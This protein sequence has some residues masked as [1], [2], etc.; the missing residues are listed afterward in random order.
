MKKRVLSVLLALSM[1]LGYILPAGS[2]TALAAEG[3]SSVGLEPAPIGKVTVENVFIDDTG[4]N[5]LDTLLPSSASIVTGE[6][7]DSRAMKGSFSVNDP[8]MVITKAM[9]EGK[10]FTVTTRAYIPGS[11]KGE[12]FNMFVSIG[13]MS[14]SFRLENGRPMAFVSDGDAWFN[15]DNRVDPD[16]SFGNKW[17]DLAVSYTGTTLIVF[18]DG[19]E[20]VVNDR[21]TASI[22]NSGVP[23]SVGFDPS[24]GRYN[25]DLLFED[26]VV[27]NEALTVEELA[28]DHAATDENILLWM[29]FEEDLVVKEEVDSGMDVDKIK[30]THKEWTG[31]DYTDVDGKAVTGEDVFGINREDASVPRIPYQDAATAASSA[32]DYNAR[33]NSVYF[34]LLTGEDRTWDLTVVQNQTL[35]QPFMDEGFMTA[36]Y[37]KDEADGWK[38]VT[39]PLSW[40]R[41]GQD[42]DFSIY[43][44]TQMPWQSKYDSNVRV[45]TAP[46][47]YNPVGLY[48]HTFEVSD[49]MLA[50]NRRIYLSFQGVESAYYVYLN[51]KEVGY[52]EDSY[53]PHRFDITDYLIDGENLLAVKV[54]KFCD[55][56]WFEDQDM[57]YDGGIFRDVYI[58]SE[59]LVKIE[60]YTV[61]TDLDADYSNAT[62]KISADVRNMSTA[63]HSGWTIQVK[64]IDESGEDILNGA[65]I[66][67]DAV[68]STETGTFEASIP[69]T[70]PK[71][72]SA[73]HPNLYAL[74]LTLV[75]GEGNE[76]E[77]LATQLGFRE[78][79]FTR[80]EVDANG[81][82]TT[83]TWTPVKINGQRLLLKGANRHDS[84]PI[85]GKTIPQATILEDLKLMKQFNFNAIRTSHYSNDEF[86]YWACNKYGIYMMAETNMECHAIMG[87]SGNIGLFY[88]LGLDRTETTFE[89]LKNN[90]AIVM[91][92]I[93]N[94]M[95]YTSDA[96]FG[97]GIFRDMIRFFKNNDATRLV[98]S[99][100]QN[101]SLGTDMGSNMYPSVGTVQGKA[102]D[103]K[104]PYVMCEYAHGMGNSIGHLKEYWDAIRSGENMLGG[105]V[106]DWVDQSRAV[107]LKDLGTKYIFTDRTGVEGETIGT[108]DQWKTEAG[109]GSLNGGHSFS[110]YTLLQN[111][112]YNKALS[113][114]GKSFTFEVIVK[115]N[116]TAQNSVLMAKGDSQVALKTKSSG[117]GIEFFFYDGS[118]HAAEGVFPENWVGNWHQVVGVYD[119]GTLTLYCDGV[120][121]GTA[122]YTDSIN[123]SSYPI[124][125]GRDPEKGRNVDG[126]ISIARIYTKALTVEEIKAQNSAEPAI[127]EDD[128]SVLLWVDYSDERTEQQLAGWDYYSED[129][130]H[131]NLYAEEME[132]KFFGYGGDWGDRPNDNSFCQNGVVSADRTPQP[133]LYE[134]KYQHQGFWFSADMEDLLSGNISVYNEY[135]FSNLNE[136]DVVWELVENGEV[137]DEGTVS[138][139]NVAPGANGTVQVNYAAP[140]NVVAGSEY[141]LNLSVR[142]K[143][144]TDLVPAGHEVAW[145]QF[146]VPVEVA[147]ARIQVSENPV[148]VKDTD[149]AIEVS[150]ENFS[151]AINKENGIMENYV[152]GG[153]LLMEQGPA[154]SFWCALTENHE[155]TGSNGIDGG[156]EGTDKNIVVESIETSV[157][158]DGRNVI[159]A[160]LI[161]PDAGN[162]SETIV[163]T[164]NGGGEVTVEMTVDATKSGMGGFV[165][166]GSTATLPAGFENITWYG[167]GPVETF[168]DRKTNARQGIWNTTVNEF[169]YP[170][171]KVDTSVLTD[172][173]WM[174]VANEELDNALVVVGQNFVETS[175]FH[176]TDED[177][178]EA[179]HP[180]ELTPREETF[181]SV[182]FGTCG[183]GGATCGP[184]TLNQ[185]RLPSSNVYNWKFTLMPV[186]ADAGSE[187]VYSAVKSYH[188][189]GS[190]VIEDIDDLSVNDLDTTMPT[191]AG[192]VDGEY[193]ATRALKGWFT[194][195]DPEM[196]LTNSMTE[197]SSF[198][199]A[200][201]V[202]VPASVLSSSTGSYDTDGNKHNMIA[203]MGDSS[204][205]LRVST[206][207][208][209]GSCNVQSFVGNGRSWYQIDMDSQGKDFVDKW[210][211][212]V[213]TYS[214]T[215]LML[216]VDGVVV[217][218]RND[219]TNN[220]VNSG[221]PFSIG[222]DPT[223]PLRTTELSFESVIVYNEA[224]TVAELEETHAP[225]DENVLLWMDFDVHKNIYGDDALEIAQSAKDI[226][227]KAAAEAQA[228]QAVAGAAA[229]LAEE[230]QAAADEVAD[231]TAENREAA[232]A[233]Q[234][235][236]DAAAAAAEEAAQIAE[237][238]Y[239]E[240]E[241]AAEAAQAAA[242][243][244]A[245]SDIKAATKAA[246]AAAAA[247]AAAKSV[248]AAAQAAKDSTE[249]AKLAAEAQKAAQLAQDKAE[250]AAAAAVDA[251]DFAEDAQASAD[252][253]KAE[254]AEDKTSAEDAKKSAEEAAAAAEKAEADAAEA[255]KVAAE[256]AAAAKQSSSAAKE[257]NLQAAK[258]ALNAAESAKIATDIASMAAEQAS[259][260]AS[261][262]AQAAAAHAKAQ[263]A[264]AE[265]ERLEQEAKDNLQKTEEELKAAQDALK[266]AQAEIEALKAA[267][268]LE[269]AKKKAVVEIALFDDSIDTD[270]LADSQIAAIDEAVLEAFADVDAALTAEDAAAVVASLKETVAEIVNTPVG[271]RFDDVKPEQWFYDAVEY[272]AANGHMI[273]VS[274]TLFNPDG[275]LTRSAFAT[276]LYRLEGEPEVDYTE[277]FTDVAEGQWYTAPILWA[278]E[279]SIVN[280][281]D[282]NSFGVDD[283]ITREQM[284]AMLYRY[285]TEY[286]GET[287]DVDADLAGFADADKINDWAL[288]AVSWAV[289]AGLIK[290]SADGDATYVNP[291]GYT[292]RAEC[293]T[294]IQRFLENVNK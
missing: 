164:I 108:D 142:T 177:M 265:A 64:A 34:Q 62:L 61:V 123:A 257:S 272:V 53:S 99:E 11:F 127:T 60:D 148:T 181:L 166:V 264:Q 197:G 255:A 256:A 259:V 121:I 69:V 139:T 87:N 77:T 4:S 275:N 85:Y 16:D 260:V 158:D 178:D 273:G 249:A 294:I 131:Q 165:Q 167:N 214:G 168:N 133:E 152:V 6:S 65:A 281:Y 195:E 161:F 90:P 36:E 185:Y 233:A 248:T 218:Q 10:D 146:Q 242:D 113:G 274:D 285:V 52:S 186:A 287:V 236:A 124:G 35:A 140:K 70:A 204:F 43:T 46:T 279:N 261:Y 93:G 54:H 250:A 254:V 188:T 63:D 172:V 32:W 187:E 27:Y 271:D 220:V 201:R 159:T 269:T 155:R 147:Q 278:S 25:S 9:T 144:A 47:N 252:A 145:K 238:A 101:A 132:G 20:Y 150:G 126:E 175:A 266:Q 30:F 231:T 223:K 28:A 71:L 115:P 293:A 212:I 196:I 169:F 136:F 74:V 111:A 40:T 222:C 31:T 51:G 282:N 284:V 12:Q 135:G 180:Y 33:E 88:E 224:L 291:Q 78:I 171:E 118:W 174:K 192:Y 125:V 240:A 143:E 59:P 13:D 81:N 79:E 116:S 55:G 19:A 162:T 170:Y 110:G 75:D 21:V 289:S 49:E 179:N 45:P 153:E 95:A 215:T 41:D 29:D 137:I 203:S 117:S 244:A 263:A 194:V 251:A 149:E 23:F 157:A 98:H 290:G 227:E 37:V 120:Q 225:E 24:T 39:L 3:T 213:V 91:W 199:I 57:I 68:A 205:G 14:M 122:T 92:S 198:T 193:A 104:I 173:V 48:R 73:E 243:A 7:E 80:T 239:A 253:A 154:P 38:E 42:F 109:E 8:D 17:H 130:A 237:G 89:R 106:W 76:V 207:R 94:E 83:R 246:K 72:W 156:W 107:D 258:E 141:Y 58:T 219:A 114:T 67:V 129:Y 190:Y 112:K 1:V 241:K 160:K 96:N 292:T 5:N 283:N 247:L 66:P 2:V 189:V 280:G 44:N 103:G 100:G 119:K 262:A 102:G 232:E 288:D 163:Y 151:F 209:G 15:A 105:F 211:D 26:V 267:A 191:T 229:K 228:A 128:E 202:F 277:I 245:Y 217:A 235:A 286:K 210:H 176:F 268:E 82:N 86:L 134:F 230:A 50:D 97:N 276:I 206:G 270:S 182:N 226:A 56:T 216:I 18:V 183:T 184:G 200:A 234:A 22:S 138:N 208:D 84:D 221:V